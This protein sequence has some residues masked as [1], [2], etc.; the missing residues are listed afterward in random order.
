MAPDQRFEM[1]SLR[2]LALA[3]LMLAALAFLVPFLFKSSPN[4][5]LAL[6]IGFGISALWAA[7]LTYGFV[8]VGRRTSWLLL[9]L[10]V[11]LFW[12][13]FLV[14]SEVACTFYNE[15]L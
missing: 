8:R 1:K 10:P 9:G 12:P 6:Y 11:S 4:M 3:S 2:N 5:G 15:C 14:L 7:L 13:A